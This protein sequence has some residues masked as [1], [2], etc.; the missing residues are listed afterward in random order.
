MHTFSKLASKRSAPLSSHTFRSKP[1]SHQS[2]LASSALTGGE[3]GGSPN[4]SSRLT[5]ER[6][7]FAVRRTSSP[8]I[9]ASSSYN[10]FSST[11]KVSL[12]T[13]ASFSAR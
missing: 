13:S 9:P 4:P 10:R 3:I 1:L 11:K 6:S 7:S 2:V 8:R 12:T 5:A